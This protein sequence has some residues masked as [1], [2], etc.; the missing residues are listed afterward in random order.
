MSTFETLRRQS[1]TLESLVDTKLNAYSRLA[2]SIATTSSARDVDLEANAT[3]EDRWTDIEEEIEGLLDKLRETSDEL[4]AALDNAPTRPSPTMTHALQRHKEVLQDYTRDFNRTKANVR[5]ARDRAN[6]LQNV[7]S[8]INAYK[9]A[10]SSAS[11]S[12]LAERGRIDSSHRMTDDLLSQAYETR[13]EFARQRSA[14]AGI[15][16]RMA[17][18]MSAFPGLNSLVSMIRSRRRR[19]AII[20]GVIIGICTLFLFSY[21]F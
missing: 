5:E 16:A 3:S 6:L 18:V 20:L 19:D 1:R 21:V 2:T 10:Q 8:D 15:N 7:R 13:D 11:D 12:L 14:I 9:A 4:A 17:S